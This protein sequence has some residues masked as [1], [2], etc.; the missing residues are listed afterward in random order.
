MKKNENEAKLEEPDSE[1]SI[2][3]LLLCDNEGQ[4]K[5]LKVST[6]RGSP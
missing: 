3:K 1:N 5:D 4:D 6:D 2:D